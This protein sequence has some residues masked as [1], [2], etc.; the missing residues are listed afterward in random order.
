MIRDVLEQSLRDA[1]SALGVEAPDSVHLERPARREHGDWS[2]N[3][4]L[5]TAKAAGRNPREFAQQISDWLTAHPPAHVERIELA[6]PG[7]VNFHLRPTWLHD[8]LTDVV[9]QG[10]ANYARF[11][12]GRGLKVNI[13][14]V[15]ANPTG[16]LHAGGGRWAA[17]GD[18]LCRL[19]ERTGHVVHREYYLNDRGT[20]MQLY[21]ASLAARKRGE[22]VPEDGYQGEYISEWAAEMPDD[23][24]PVEW[25]YERVK[26]DLRETLERMNVRFDTWFSERSLVDSGAVDATLAELRENDMAYD[27]DGAVWIRTEQFG[28]RKDQ[29]IVRSTGEPAYLLPDLA[30]HRDKF[31]R[32]WELLIDIWGADHHGYLP[33]LKAG[34]TCLGHEPDE[35]EIILGQLVTLMRDGQPVRLSKRA[36]DLVLLSDLLEAVGPDVARLTFLLQSLD[37]RQTIDLGAVTAQS[38]ENPV[39][40]VQM[41]HARIAGI[42]RRAQEIGLSRLPLEHTELNL[43]THERE[44]DVLR[45]LSE[46]PEVVAIAVRERA[47]HKITTWVREL[48]DR[49]HGFYHDCYVIGEGVSPEVTQARL[50]LVESARIGLA[51][52]LDLLGVSAPESM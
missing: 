13:E 6:G 34:L 39:F 5:A 23:V 19:F 48:A 47:P 9:E 43:L 26:R 10:E 12:I 32:G 49:F 18:A 31:S 7:F 52:G 22:P 51:I 24:D 28:D 45:S 40:Y 21:G 3:V 38:M 20:Q 16:P 37:T 25:G 46:L 2:S 27:A 33:S 44:L 4:A 29:V 11:D 8:V 1:L 14:F 15:S 41:A 30:Y 17:Y 35:L 42:G 36:G 50:W